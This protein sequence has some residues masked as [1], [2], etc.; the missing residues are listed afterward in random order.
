[1]RDIANIAFAFATLRVLQQPLRDALSSEALHKLSRVEPQSLAFLTEVGLEVSS[2]P[3][4]LARMDDIIGRLFAALP[5]TVEQWR[6]GADLRNL[7]E[8]RI[9]HLGS[10]GTRLMLERAQVPPP[11]EAFTQRASATFPPWGVV[12]VGASRLGGHL[13]PRGAPVPQQRRIFCYA[14]YAF[15]TPGRSEDLVEGRLLREHGFQGLRRWQK[16][17]LRATTLPVNPNVDRSVCAEFQVLNELCDLV[18][19]EGLAD[20]LAQC[21]EVEGSVSMLVSTTPC[22][23]CVGAVLQFSLLLPK[24]VLKFGC[25]QPWHAEGGLDGALLPGSSRVRE[26]G[27]DQIAPATW[28]GGFLVE[29]WVPSG[30]QAEGAQEPQPPPARRTQ[31]VRRPPARRAMST[32]ATVVA[33]QGQA[34]KPVDGLGS[35]TGHRLRP[36]RSAS[37]SR[38]AVRWH[39][40]AS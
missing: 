7:R 33:V 10:V 24:V 34:A 29:H 18:H 15:C 35:S 31:P 6:R 3:V 26:G 19:Q 17:W 20:D 11:D 22:L 14:E 27:S 28:E 1:M 21:A 2:H 4:L 30:E 16:G 37:T 23:S 39:R 38:P 12:V 9:D 8:V 36:E 25:I 5:K 40:G 32:P 13:V